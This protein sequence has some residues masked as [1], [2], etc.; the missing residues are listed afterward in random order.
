M[1]RDGLD[2]FSLAT[3]IVSTGKRFAQNGS[4]AHITS[5]RSKELSYTTVHLLECSHSKLTPAAL[6]KG[7]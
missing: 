1:T 7:Y 5:G 4:S 2:D 3:F 6:P